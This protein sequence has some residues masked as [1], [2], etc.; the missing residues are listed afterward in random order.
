MNKHNTMKTKETA[1]HFGISKTTLCRWVARG[2]PH[3]KIADQHIFCLEKVE[4][5]IKINKNPDA[6]GSYQLK[7]RRALK[8][9]QVFTVNS[10]YIGEVYGSKALTL[11]L[12]QLESRDHFYPFGVDEQGFVYFVYSGKLRKHESVKTMAGISIHTRYPPE[13]QA[14]MDL[15]YERYIVIRHNLWKK[16][17]GGISSP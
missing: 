1:N 9:Y 12:K 3:E 13:L 8:R 2:C 4:E 10:K 5:W 11:Q 6:T 15:V 14:L 16:P 17:S 7:S